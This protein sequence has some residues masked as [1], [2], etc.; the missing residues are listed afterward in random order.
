MTRFSVLLFCL[1]QT[2]CLAKQASAVTFSDFNGA[3]GI[4]SAELLKKQGISIVRIDVPWSD[5]EKIKGRYNF[6]KYDKEIIAAKEAGFEVLPVLAYVPEWNKILK[7][8]I[9]SPPLD[10]SSWNAFVA[11]TVKRYRANPFNITYFQVWNEPTSKAKFWLGNNVDFVNNIYIPAAKIIKKN[12]GKVVFGGWP[13]SNSI[14]EFDYV[15]DHLGAIKYTDI[16]D[17]HYRDYKSYIKLYDKYIQTNMA[18]GIWQSELGYSSK[19]QNLLSSYLKII[20]WALSHNWKT[21]DTYKV[22]WYPAWASRDKK[23]YGLATTLRDRTNVLTENGNE[24]VLLNMLYGNG[25][26]ANQEVKSNMKSS[27]DAADYFFGVKIDEKQVIIAVLLGDVN[28]YN[29]L[30]YSLVTRKEPRNVTLISAKGEQYKLNYLYE[31]GI[32]HLFIDKN[33]VVNISSGRI[34]IFFIK[35]ELF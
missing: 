35:V 2:L 18:E 5:I 17:F 31:K 19:P 6:E 21:S 4:T 15:L 29:Q 11:A 14:S 9:G 16:I 27:L 28:K 25:N 26:L 22:F 10:I 24:L 12:K 34:N 1:L 23:Q 8:K 20:S 13:L 3:N 32:T 7:G 33:S 30:H